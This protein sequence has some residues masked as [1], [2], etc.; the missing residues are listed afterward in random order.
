MRIALHDSDKMDFPNYA[1]MKISAWHKLC[2]DTV[3]WFVP[4][5][6]YDTVYSSK[7][8]TFTPEDPTLPPD[9]IR[10]GTG[11]DM[12]S[13][14]PDYIDACFPDYTLYG[15]NYSVGF[16]TRGCN[17]RCPHCFVPEK[18]GDVRPYRRIADIILPGHSSAVLMDNNVLAHPHGIEQIEEIARLG[19]KVDFNQGLDARLIDDT[20][21]RRLSRVKWLTPLRLACDHSSQ[22]EIV[23]RAIES[24]RWHNVTP[25]QYFCYVL[26]DDIPDA[27]QRIRFLKGMACDAF[28]QPF[29]PP[30]G[31]PPTR[32]Q[33]RLA[34]WVN[35]KQLYRG[36]T[37][38]DYRESR[39]DLI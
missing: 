10:G 30:D 32:D 35:L 27:I 16:L 33:R 5:E 29:I 34:R 39:G 9:T 25:R 13:A 22:I 11:Y 2:G 19:I 21:A 4:G 14:L 37:W 31:T 28:A 20:M 24:L 15:L 7:V 6:R 38:E 26:V 1:L 36:M 3:E 23:R 18:E 12:R 8:F 17:R